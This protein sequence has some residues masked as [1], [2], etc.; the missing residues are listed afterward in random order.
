MQLTIGLLLLLI[1]RERGGRSASSPPQRSWCNI[2][3]CSKV[4]SGPNR[5]RATATKLLLRIMNSRYT[6]LLFQLVF[7]LYRRCRQTMDELQFQRN[8]VEY[9]KKKEEFTVV[10]LCSPTR[11]EFGLFNMLDYKGRQ[12]NAPKCESHMESNG[13][14]FMKV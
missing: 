14:F 6:S 1:G 3:T 10:C 12:Q 4:I 2:I 5:T 13:F 7:T 9:K 11:L 8:G